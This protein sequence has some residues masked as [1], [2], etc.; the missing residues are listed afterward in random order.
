MSTNNRIP[1]SV[2]ISQDD[3]DFI[4]SLQIDGA[5]TPSEK[6]RELLTQARHAHAGRRDY[7]SML[8]HTEMLLHDA[9]HA[10]LGYEREI[11]IHS[12]IVARLHELIPDLIATLCGGMPDSPD[13]IELVRYE[14][15][16]MWRVVRLMDSVLQLA[17]TGR[18]AG[19]DD[20]VLN[21]LD[22][23][24]ALAQIIKLS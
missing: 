13:K 1:I 10:L 23:T 19:Y 5:N 12:N 11:G 2:R 22:N 6:V 18:G 4:A 9:R 8:T 16:L 17:I 7:E 24:L 3:A 14:R 20:T 21:E 15:E